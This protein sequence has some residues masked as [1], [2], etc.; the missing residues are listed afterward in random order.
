MTGKDKQKLNEK[1]TLYANAKEYF[2]DED[3]CKQRKLICFTDSLDACFKWLVPKLNSLVLSYRGYD[4][5]Y[6]AVVSIEP[7]TLEFT[8]VSNLTESPSLSL[9]LAIEKLIDSKSK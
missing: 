7:G 1:L 6:G 5:K 4:K 3:G 8:F 2:T 9:C